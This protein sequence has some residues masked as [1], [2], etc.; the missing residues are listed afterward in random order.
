[1]DRGNTALIDAAAALENRKDRLRRADQGSGTVGALGRDVKEA[2]A[3]AAVRS[4]VFFMGSGIGRTGGCTLDPNRL[5]SFWSP[6]LVASVRSCSVP[7]HLSSL[8]LDH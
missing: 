8:D 2:A 5:Y 3:T 6:L 4:D 7:Q 1:M